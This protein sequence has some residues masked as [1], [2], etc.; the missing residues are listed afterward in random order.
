[1]SRV[2]YDGTPIDY[3]PGDSL[4][5]AALRTGQHPA[6]GGT[7]CL[8]G[9]CGEILQIERF[10]DQPYHAGKSGVVRWPHQQ[11]PSFRTERHGVPPVARCS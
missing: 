1:M 6:R 10:G 11:D 3:Q 5:L 2:V 7:L 4:A 8:A 9:D